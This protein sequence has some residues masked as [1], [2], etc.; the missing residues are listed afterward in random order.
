MTLAT[1]EAS[2]KADV[3]QISLGC[4]FTGVSGLCALWLKISFIPLIL[5]K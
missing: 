2:A 4:L 1:A 5:S 3:K